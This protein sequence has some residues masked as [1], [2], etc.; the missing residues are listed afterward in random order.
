MDVVIVRLDVHLASWL[1]E[2][3]RGLEQERQW[4]GS[5]G[6]GVEGGGGV[7]GEWLVIAEREGMSAYFW[8]LKDD[9]PQSSFSASLLSLLTPL[10][11]PPH[12]FSPVS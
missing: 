2:S 12:L 3:T 4:G 9:S 8:H 6:S 7:W 5:F 1:A 10:L 11:R